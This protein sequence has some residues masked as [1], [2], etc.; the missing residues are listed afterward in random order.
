MECGKVIL[1]VAATLVA[2]V[3]VRADLIPVS[4]G[5]VVNRAQSP[6]CDR[7]DLASPAHLT[8]FFPSLDVDPLPVGSLTEGWGG[9]EQ[10]GETEDVPVLTERQDSLTL[11]LYALFS[12]GLCKSAPWVKK[13][14]LGVIPGWYHDGGPFQVGHSLAISPDCLDPAPT[15]CLVQPDCRDKVP[16]P[17]SHGEAIVSRWRKSQFSPAVEAPRG[18]PTMS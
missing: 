17:Q 6:M 14:S 8:L 13:L 2:A 7:A 1:A 3:V 15:Y 16:M 18:P 4:T 9:D 12:L 5:D 11:C 10:T